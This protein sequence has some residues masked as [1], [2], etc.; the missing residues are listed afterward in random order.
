[1]KMNQKGKGKDGYLT[2]AHIYSHL[3]SI[4]A[5]THDAACTRGNMLSPDGFCFDEGRDGLTDSWEGCRVFCNPPFSDKASWMSKA[6]E[7]VSSGRCPVC[8]MVL[9]TNSM[10]QTFWHKYVYGK[11]HYE[12]LDGRAAFINPDTMKPDTNNTSGTTIIYFMMKPT[13]KPL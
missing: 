11:Y 4:F 8:I 10:A 6:H 12:I 9:P 7:E 2:P 1:M 3:N 13:V 5:F